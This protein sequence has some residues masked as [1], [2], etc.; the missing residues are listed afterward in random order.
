MSKKYDTR[1]GVISAIEDISFGVAPGE[2][3]CLVGPSGCGKST[4]LRL[5]AGLIRPDVGQV[6]LHG[7]PLDGPSRK[8]GLVFQNA[9]L[10]PWRTVLDNVMLPLQVQQV[11][12][13][14]TRQRAI[15]ALALVGLTDFMDS[16]P[17]QLSGG[18]AQR[19]AI[20]RILVQKPEVLL[21]DE[22]FGAL[23]ALTRERLNQEL[24]RLWE[25]SRESVV[26]VTHNIREAVFLADRVLVLT[27]RPGRVAAAIPID[28]PRPRARSLLY[29]SEEFNGLASRVRQAIQ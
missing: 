3:V 21:L 5:L 10:M 9:N 15:K 6:C 27:Q 17:H 25:V 12:E 29:D 18:M 11:P 14:E 13:E 24:M 20:A 2:F 19:V 26:M 4:L 23:D 8:I 7:K 16:Y 22:P 1:R 28:L